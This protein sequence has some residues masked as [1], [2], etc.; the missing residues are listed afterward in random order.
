MLQRPN[1][2]KRYYDLLSYQAALYGNTLRV[3]QP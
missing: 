2:G 1:D 3:F